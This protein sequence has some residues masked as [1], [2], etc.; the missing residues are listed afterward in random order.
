MSWPGER[1]RHA[2]SARGISTK[3]QNSINY[4]NK[5]LPNTIKI[6]Q[7]M[8]SLLGSV[9]TVYGK[10]GVWI[11]TRVQNANE[12]TFELV[13]NYNPAESTIAHFGNINFKQKTSTDTITQNSQS[14]GIKEDLKKTGKNMEHSGKNIAKDINKASSNVN[15]RITKVGKSIAKD[16]NRW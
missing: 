2:M 14:R 13:N 1:Q 11:V 12:G 3:R 8:E 15:I 10:E 4:L 5:N 16:I 7:A 9:V 6:R